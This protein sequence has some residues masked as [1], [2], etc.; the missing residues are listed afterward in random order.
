MLACAGTLRKLLRRSVIGHTDEGVGTSFP[1]CVECE[2]VITRPE[3][4]P[5]TPHLMLV[6]SLAC[7]AV[8]LYNGTSQTRQMTLCSPVLNTQFTF[9]QIRYDALIDTFA[10]ESSLHEE[11]KE[12]FCVA[13][14]II[15]FKRSNLLRSPHRQILARSSQRRFARAILLPFCARAFHGSISRASL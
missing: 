8:V 9:Q 14:S 1:V 10:S 6:P 2:F 5:V 11:K 12:C 15:R 7:R 3:I 13:S 4:V